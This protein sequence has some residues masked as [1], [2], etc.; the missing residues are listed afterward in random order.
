MRAFASLKV[1]LA[2]LLKT[3]QTLRDVLEATATDKLDGAQAK[4]VRPVANQS[5]NREQV[6]AYG[7]ISKP[8]SDASLSTTITAATTR[9]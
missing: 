1:A 3:P 6:A 9:A 7:Q 4:F 5:L 2:E 8:T